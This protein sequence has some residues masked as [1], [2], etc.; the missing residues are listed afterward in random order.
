MQISGLGCE[1]NCFCGGALSHKI[2]NSPRLFSM[3]EPIG[4]IRSTPRDFAIKP[5]RKKL[6]SGFVPGAE[7]NE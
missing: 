6:S 3:C 1:H 4:E 2:A 7:W 5:Q